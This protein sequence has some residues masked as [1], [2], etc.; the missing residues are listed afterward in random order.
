MPLLTNMNSAQFMLDLFESAEDRSDLISAYQDAWTLSTLR[1]FSVKAIS[2]M[3][4][5]PQILFH[6]QLPQNRAP[7]LVRNSDDFFPEIPTSHP[8]HVFTNAHNALFTQHLNLI[9]DWDMFQTVH[10]YS[11]FHAAAR[12]VSGGPIYITDVPGQHDLDLINQMTGLTPRGKTVIFRP[13][14]IGK[15]LDQYNGYD[16]DHILPIGTYHGAAYTGTGIIGFFNVSQKPLSELVPLS[17]FPGVEEAQFYIVRAYSTGAIS[18]PM[19]VVDSQALIYVSLAVRGYDILSAYPLRGFV[20]QK[21]DNNTTWVANLGLLGKMAG[22]AAIVD[23]KI[24]QS[25]NGKIMI[26]TNVKALGTLGR[27]QLSF[28]PTSNSNYTFRNLHFNTPGNIICR[29][30]AGHHS[31]KGSASSYSYYQQ[32]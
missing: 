10:D 13:S 3:S 32:R 23:S 27:F 28:K 16:D 12:C 8:W 15:S 24:T 7:I 19:Q 25:E 1:H 6:S 5:I 31:W 22:A 2:C 9:P 21:K 4:Q 17:K 26:D 29:K 30:L 18:K 20:D 11:G 14:V